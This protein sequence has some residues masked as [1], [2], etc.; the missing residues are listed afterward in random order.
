[1]SKDIDG[2]PFTAEGYEN[3]KAILKAEYGQPTE[4]VNAYIKNIMELPI[5]RGANPRKVKEFYKQI[6]ERSKSFI[7]SCAS[8]Y[9][10][11]KHLDVSEM[12]RET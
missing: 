2:L 6:Q 3:A 10:V 9:K 1:M 8:T 12:S 7:N 4:I 11:W 5:I